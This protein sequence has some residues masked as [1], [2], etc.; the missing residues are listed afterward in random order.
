MKIKSSF[1]KIIFLLGIFI[2]QTFIYL[3]KR[4]LLRKVS[5]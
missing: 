3:S 1:F 4:S 2:I 5:I